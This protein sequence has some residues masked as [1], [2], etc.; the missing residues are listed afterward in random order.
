MTEPKDEKNEAL[1]SISLP[2]LEKGDAVLVSAVIQDTTVHYRLYKRRWVGLLGIC[3]LNIIASVGL[4]WFPSIAVTASKEFGISLERIN[5]LSNCNNVVYLPV[6]VMI[7]MI[8][9]RYG[10]RMS[11]FV[12]TALMFIATWVRYAGTASSLSSDGKFVL[13]LLAQIL[14]AFGQ[15]WFQ[16]LGPKYSELWFDLKGRTTS[17]T[18][19]ALSNPVGSAVGHLVAPF[20]PTVRSSVYHI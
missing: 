4:T 19:I 18:L 16:V 9:S 20:C 11:C 6:S 17:T 13:L 15:P 3:I 12:G 2:T 1:V 10:L 14:L 5:W 8:S 7:P